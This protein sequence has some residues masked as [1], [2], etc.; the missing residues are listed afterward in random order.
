MNASEEREQILRG[1]F[2]SEA[3]QVLGKPAWRAHS[4]IVQIVFFFLT[5]IGMGATYGLLE[6]FD[7][8]K[9]GIFFGIGA[10]ALAEH[11]IRVRKWF[12]TGVEAALWLGAMLA[13][14]ME[15]PSSGRDESLLVIAAA[16]AIAGARVR[17]PLF[18][19]VA[20]AF[21]IEYA[22]RAADL[23]MLAGIAIGT[24]AGLALLRTWQRS[25]TEW[26]WIAIVIVAP[27]AGRTQAD[28]RWLP[29]TIALSLVFGLVMLVLGVTRRHHALIAA[30]AI[31][32]GIAATD[33]ASRIAVPVE[34]KLALGGALLLAVSFVL[35]RMLRDRTTGLVVTPLQATPLDLALESAGTIA[36]ADA[37]HP[38]LPAGDS[39]PQGDGGFG[40]AGASGNY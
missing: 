6:I 37:A 1:R 17:N 14:I 22:E 18:G 9:P 24:A 34:A 15:L 21:V 33:V 39:R 5:C 12:F 27:V 30:G 11:L 10:I 13:F 25:S 7:V 19:A 38:D 26:L 3:E 23:G 36:A 16:I 8:P 2:S 29:V 40:G 20:V 28:E 31:G 35:G 4:V 32:L